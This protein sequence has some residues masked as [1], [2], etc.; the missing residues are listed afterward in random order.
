[1]PFTHQVFGHCKVSILD[2]GLPKWLAEGYPTMSGPPGEVDTCP[3][4]A[5]YNPA[6]VMDMR[7]MMDNLSSKKMQVDITLY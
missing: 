3:F 2:G 6:L 5:M 1:M 7:Q 4:K